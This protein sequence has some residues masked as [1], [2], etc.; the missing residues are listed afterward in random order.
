M[1]NIIL[2]GYR[3]TGKS[4]V[5]KE[6]SKV[7]NRPFVDTDD[8]ITSRSGM[9]IREM[10][11]QGGWDFFREREKAVVRQLPPSSG[12]IIATGGGI[13]DDEEN[14]QILKQCGICVW[15]TAPV[16]TIMKRMQA[17][18]HT[19]DSRPALCSADDESEI[20]IM[21]A[22]RDPIYRQAADMIIDTSNKSIDDVVGEIRRFV[23]HTV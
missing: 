13:L 1:K 23:S 16:E 22:R 8:L 21:L 9:S 14:R 20:A 12:M 17:D 11:E 7:L 15:L 5:G 10:V 6:L 18:R 19:N 4:T 2:I 3:C